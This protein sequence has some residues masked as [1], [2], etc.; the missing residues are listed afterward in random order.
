MKYFLLILGLFIVNTNTIFSQDLRLDNKMFVKRFID[1][2]KNNNKTAI[3]N[4]VV[5]PLHRPFP[6]PDIKNQEE[7][8][9]RY[10]QIF[11][12]NLKELINNSTLERNW[13]E[14][15]W[16]GISFNNGTMW[17]TTEG[18]LYQINYTSQN[19]TNL[20]KTLI[21]QD[22]KKLHHSLLPF[23]QPILLLKT[24]NY[25]IRIDEIDNQQFRYASWT[26]K[27]PISTKPDLMLYGGDLIVE[28]G[29]MGAYKYVFKNGEFVYECGINPLE[30][31]NA[32]LLVYKGGQELLFEVAQIVK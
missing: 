24:K 27:Q 21:E 2:V 20:K 8:V 31:N 4:M 30:D 23:K 7:F 32:Y 29:S 5:Y 15:G 3:A 10:N 6:I 25:T 17:L 9:Q 16:R 18:E 22:K 12:A 11:D 19:E 13:T 28:Q 1:Y 14:V 26:K